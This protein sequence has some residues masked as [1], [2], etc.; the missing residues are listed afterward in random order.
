MLGA[1]C[2]RTDFPLSRTSF[3]QGYGYKTCKCHIRGQDPS[4][5]AQNYCASS[6]W[7][8]SPPP[9]QPAAG[10]HLLHGALTS[11]RCSPCSRVASGLGHGVNAGQTPA[12]TFPSLFL[13]R[14]VPLPGGGAEILPAEQPSEEDG[15]GMRRGYLFNRFLLSSEHMCSNTSLEN[16]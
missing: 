6:Y 4:L 12:R 2:Y 15:V 11:P 5:G 7:M 10:T 13:A 8:A 3:S 1:L 16:M 9:E 14:F